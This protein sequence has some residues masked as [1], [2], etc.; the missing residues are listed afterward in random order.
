M[1]SPAAAI[2]VVVTVAY[3]VLVKM[4]HKFTF[5]HLRVTIFSLVERP[6]FPPKL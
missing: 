6:L 3:D 2:V 5:G 4:L 1:L